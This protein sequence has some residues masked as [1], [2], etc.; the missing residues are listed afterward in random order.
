MFIE[1][2]AQEDVEGGD[3]IGK[4]RVEEQWSNKRRIFRN[5]R[6]NGGQGKKRAREMLALRR[7]LEEDR[8]KTSVEE[9]NCI[10]EDKESKE[11]C[12]RKIPGGLQGSETALQKKQERLRK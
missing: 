7:N 8:R 5:M 3:Q 2:E 1:N 10:S 12:K 6:G 11:R 9:K 4:E